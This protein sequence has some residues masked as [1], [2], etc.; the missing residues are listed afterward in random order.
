MVVV[1]VCGGGNG[2][3]T[4]A[5]VAA[6]RPNT[7]VRVLTLFAD[8]AERWTKAMESS[9][10]VTNIHNHDKSIT[11]LTNKPRLV[12]KD[13]GKAAIGA[14]IIILAV[15][16]FVHA[17]YLE[18]LKPH[19]TPGTIL[20]GLPGQPGFEFDVYTIW[21]PL[22]SKCSIMAFESLPW[23]CRIAEFG[24]CVE[25]LGTKESLVGAV[26]IGSVPS[27][28]DPTLL[29]QGCLGPHPSLLT[30][31]HLLGITL[32]SVNSYIH[33]SIL[34]G[35]W[36]DWNGTPLDEAPLFYQ[37]IDQD[38]ADLMSGMS[39]EILVIAKEIMKK[40][41]KVDLHNVDHVLQWYLRVYEDD[42]QDKSN[43]YTAI[44]SN[45]AYIGLTHPM[46]KTEDG[47]YLPNFKHRYLSEDIPYGLAVSKGVAEVVGVNTPLI[48]KVLIW[49]QEKLGKEYLVDGKMIGKDV[50]FTRCPQ[51]YSMTT[52]DAILGK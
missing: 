16:A 47:K 50:T 15:P 35:R 22:A 17:Q 13:P 8:E 33:S 3:H 32:M 29:L 19:V 7:E 51:R 26:H 9:D 1:V 44:R 42:I 10:F 27:K 20:V 21:G 52:V 48:D 36:H 18:A 4:L 2:A 43:L 37:G 24:Q 28:F 5:G 23:A 49:C 41:P 31:G 38:T 40:N 45:E 12:T 34:Y 25:I 14:E 30:K 11:K 39:D 46:S 6:S